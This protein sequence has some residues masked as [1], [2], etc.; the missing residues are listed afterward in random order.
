MWPKSVPHE[1]TSLERL[2][3]IPSELSYLQMCFVVCIS[4]CSNSSCLRFGWLFP[5]LPHET[6]CSLS[7]VHRNT[8]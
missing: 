2:S 8:W 5:G 1:F 3:L 7:L 6:A 4:H